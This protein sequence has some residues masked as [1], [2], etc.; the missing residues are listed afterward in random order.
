MTSPT[1]A[2]TGT[3]LNSPL[4]EALPPVPGRA[5]QDGAEPFEA[6]LREGVEQRLF[7]GGWPMSPARLGG[8]KLGVARRRVL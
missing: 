2:S 7:V 4:V 6:A 1:K 5:G 8:V 3:F